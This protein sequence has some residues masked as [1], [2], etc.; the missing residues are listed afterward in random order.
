MKKLLLLLPL[1]SVGCSQNDGPSAPV[2]KKTTQNLNRSEEEIL[3]IAEAA[4]LLK[5]NEGRSE[6]VAVDK[7]S[8]KPISK[9]YGRSEN[10][11]TLIYAVNFKDDNG[12]VLISAKEGVTPIIGIADEG[13]FDNA[14]TY[15]NKN[16]QFFID[17]AL[18]YVKSSSDAASI[19]GVSSTIAYDTIKEYTRYP[20]RLKTKWGPDWPENM[21]CPNGI[22]G[23]GPVA[24]AQML[25]YY[26]D[27]KEIEL[28]FSERDKDI[29]T[30]NWKEIKRHESTDPQCHQSR[31][32]Y[33]HQ[34]CTA[35]EE[36]HKVIGRFIRQ[37]GELSDTYYDPTGTSTSMHKSYE[38]AQ[39]LMPNRTIYLLLNGSEILYDMKFNNSI[40]YSGKWEI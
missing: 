26:E 11:D 8:I 30:L 10:A 40:G 21:Y 20:E 33:Y 14:Q 2:E 16:F 39:S 7:T 24:L 23:C 28:T 34:I 17:N 18:D 5:G 15:S 9:K 3:R 22:A 13:A 37:L 1:I 25:A 29:Q 12:F 32:D 35:D 38:V 4:S 31:S 36:T 19:Q 6:R 27:T